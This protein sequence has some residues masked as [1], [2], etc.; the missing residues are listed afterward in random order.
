MN[1]RIERNAL[2]AWALVVVLLGCSSAPQS[3]SGDASS[4]GTPEQSGGK[5]EARNES[6]T[7]PAGTAIAVLLASGIDT[8]T[9]AEGSSFEATL[10][11]PLMVNGTEA[12]AVGST[13][14]GTITHVVSSGRLS[15]PAELSLTLT[16]LTPKGGDKVAITTNTWSEK[17]ESHKKRNVEMIGGGTAGGGLIGALAGG[18]KGAAIGALVGGGGGT[19]VAAGTGKKEIRLASEVKLSFTLS[20]AITLPIIKR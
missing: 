18:K 14:T 2:L 6:V 19:A 13:V 1:S 20:Q 9:A 11:G 10:A 4:A 15:R 7:I 5:K 17:G 12:A 8:G 16:S 3:Q